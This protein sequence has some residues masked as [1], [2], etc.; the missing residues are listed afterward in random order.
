MTILIYCCQGER[1]NFLVKHTGKT[2]VKLL[3]LD[4]LH[5]DTQTVVKVQSFGANQQQDC[6]LQLNLDY[7]LMSLK[8]LCGFLNF[9]TIDS[10]FTVVFGA[11]A[12]INDGF[13][14]GGD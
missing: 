9:E 13:P 1:W 4:N 5:I 8:F 6:S 12:G 10:F 7:L 14:L 3:L 11:D 2:H